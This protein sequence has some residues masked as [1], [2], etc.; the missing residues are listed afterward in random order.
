MNL[1]FFN[2]CTKFNN[3]EY[4]CKHLVCDFFATHIESL[5]VGLA[6]LPIPG[7]AYNIPELVIEDGR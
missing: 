1:W 7:L 6:V 4:S 5:V 3:K 2:V